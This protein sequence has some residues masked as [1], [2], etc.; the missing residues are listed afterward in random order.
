MLEIVTALA[1]TIGIA[2]P[3][4]TRAAAQAH[5]EA[6]QAVLSRPLDRLI[7]AN[8][9]RFDPAFRPLQALHSARRRLL[10]RQ[11]ADTR[12]RLVPA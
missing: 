10:Y 5:L 3:R 4:M 8:L 7:L 1:P 11:G 9:L 12:L 2:R 6:Q